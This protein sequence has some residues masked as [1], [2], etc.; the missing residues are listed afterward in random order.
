MIENEWGDSSFRYYATRELSLRYFPQFPI[1]RCLHYCLFSMTNTLYFWDYSVVWDFDTIIDYILMLLWQAIL[2]C[3]KIEK[4]II[5]KRSHLTKLK[6]W[7]FWKNRGSSRSDAD[8]QK[9][10][11]YILM[12]KFP[13]PQPS[14][15]TKCF[16]KLS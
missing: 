12:L 13:L 10:S 4:I 5:R 7:N 9:Y 14:F 8:K 16:A 15:K 3:W 2:S 11:T 1:E 6:D